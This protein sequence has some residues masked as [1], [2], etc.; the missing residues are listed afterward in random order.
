MARSDAETVEAYMTEL[1]EDRR[2]TIAAVLECVRANLPDGYEET[3]RWG[4]ISWEI[5]LERYPDTY[6]DAPL[7]YVGLAAQKNYNAL[8]LMGVYG[9]EEREGRLR[10]AFEAAGKKMDMGKSC[11]RFRT[12]EDLPLDAVGEIVAGMP[13]DELIAKYE[14]SR[15]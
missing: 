13:P 8:Y 7:Q 6:N 3:M 12:V 15:R 9:D 10:N 11:L 14:A 4:R 5:P 1:P 2:E